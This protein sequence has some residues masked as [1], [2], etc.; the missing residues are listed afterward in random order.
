[1]AGFWF[2]LL[3]RPYA[4][5]G[6]KNPC[7]QPLPGGQ[8]R[9]RKP[10]MSRGRRGSCCKTSAQ[11]LTSFDCTLPKVTGGG[12]R[13]AT[14]AHSGRASLQTFC[15][16]PKP[17]DFRIGIFGVL[18][19]ILTPSAAKPMKA[20]MQRIQ[21]ALTLGNLSPTTLSPSRHT[22]GDQP[23]ILSDCSMRRLVCFL[24]LLASGR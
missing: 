24:E 6:I 19:P 14:L 8:F 1:M 18:K 9:C 2:V 4:Q 21:R 23:V 5:G 11:L 17:K 7:S 12:P 15:K 20:T 3:L 16:L 13:T 10:Y 22:P